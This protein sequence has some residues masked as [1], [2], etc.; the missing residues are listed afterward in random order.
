MQQTKKQKLRVKRKKFG[1]VLLLTGF[2]YLVQ[3][4]FF[5]DALISPISKQSFA[6][7]AAVL[8]RKK[9]AYES[10]EKIDNYYLIRMKDNGEV[11]IPDKK[12]LEE[13]VSSLQLIL[14]RLKIEGKTFRRLD[15]RYEKTVILF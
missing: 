14:A 2:S 4:R 15:F 7:I 6:S 11:L 3:L 13:Q 9:I 8:E 5:P 10:I 1:L 12:N